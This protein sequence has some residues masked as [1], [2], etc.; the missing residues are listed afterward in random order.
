M[1]CSFASLVQIV[2]EIVCEGDETNPQK[3]QTK[4]MKILPSTQIL[5]QVN[6]VQKISSAEAEGNRIAAD[7]GDD[8]VNEVATKW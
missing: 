4:P 3:H 6:L 7:K 8:C 2:T 1:T 5:V